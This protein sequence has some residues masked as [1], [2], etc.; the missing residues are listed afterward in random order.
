MK[1]ITLTEL[2]TAIVN[3]TKAI[4]ANTAAKQGAAT[5]TVE[6]TE[7]AKEPV[8]P[9]ETPASTEDDA[10]ETDGI[11]LRDVE[12]ALLEVKAA[13]GAAK[14]QTLL[15]DLTGSTSVKKANPAQYQAIIDACEAALNVADDEPESKPE[16]AQ[17][18]D[19]SKMEELIAE[20]AQS[21][22]GK[23]KPENY[24]TAKRLIKT[25]G[26]A[27]KKANI[28]DENIQPMIVALEKALAD[29]NGDDDL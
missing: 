8:E 2:Y 14:T 24:E 28:A 13:K 15:K 6:K 29:L 12:A 3:L 20:L 26:N 10:T 18:G 22:L 25:V 1:E 21:E 16:P 27:D 5:V 11:A 19:R 23:G 7:T 9:K 4:E 17:Q